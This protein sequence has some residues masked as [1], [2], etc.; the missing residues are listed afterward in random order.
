MRS[1]NQVEKNELRLQIKECLIFES[2]WLRA[3][4][5]KQ[6]NVHLICSQSHEKKNHVF[7][8]LVKCCFYTD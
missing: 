8:F 1:E 5:C 3:R 7:Y 2:T 6:I 4:S